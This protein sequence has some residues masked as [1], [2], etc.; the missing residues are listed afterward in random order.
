MGGDFR[1]AKAH[2]VLR[3]LVMDAA[4]HRT[5]IARKNGSAG[6]GLVRI[7]VG[8]VAPDPLRRVGRAVDPVIPLDRTDLVVQRTRRELRPA[9]MGIS[10]RL[11]PG[12][13]GNL[14]RRRTQGRN[15]ADG[16]HLGG[17]L[18][19]PGNGRRAGWERWELVFRPSPG[20]RHQQRRRHRR[21]RQ[22]QKC[23]SP[24]AVGQFLRPTC[25]VLAVRAF[26]DSLQLLV[27]DTGRAPRGVSG[28]NFTGEEMDSLS[29][30]SFCLAPQNVNNL[31]K[32]HVFQNVNADCHDIDAPVCK[33]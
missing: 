3:Q 6:H 21:C 32:V 15:R 10:P 19:G 33:D 18:M 27:L 5:P 22:F 11:A 2:V 20:A 25:R 16:I 30:R 8:L 7:V 12:D 26:H 4:D 1:R 17:Q 28:R 29:N 14:G 23:P 24:L 13:V 31:T 9:L